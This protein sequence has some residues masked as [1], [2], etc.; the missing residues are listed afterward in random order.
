[1]TDQK[2]VDELEKALRD[3]AYDGGIGALS[4]EEFRELVRTLAVTAG[5]VVD[6]LRA[7][8]DNEKLIEEAARAILASEG[9]GPE[10]DGTYWGEATWPNAVKDARTAF[11]VF[12]KAHTPTDDE[13]EALIDTMRN[14]PT[15][16]N[17]VVRYDEA[18]DAI[19]AAGFRRT[20]VPE[21]S[22][23]HECEFGC[24]S[25]AEHMQRAYDALKSEYEGY[26]QWVRIAFSHDIAEAD[27]KKIAS[28]Y[29]WHMTPSGAGLRNSAKAM[30]AALSEYIKLRVEAAH[31][32]QGSEGA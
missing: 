3:E 12:E 29:V 26:R 14:A 27:A 17:I 24:A 9:I 4:P 10:E 18:A 7:P 19:L 22:A 25:D 28:R 6:E 15:H 23:E 32:A 20:V 2:L 31:A 5:K 13:R 30:Q 11:A 21:P 1:M 8:T 16:G